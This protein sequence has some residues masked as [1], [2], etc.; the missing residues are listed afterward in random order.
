VVY[1]DPNTG[2][3][4]IGIAKGNGIAKV[5]VYKDEIFP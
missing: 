3:P 4:P 5:D 2:K 1:I